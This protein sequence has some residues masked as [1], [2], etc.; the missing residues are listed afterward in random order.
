MNYSVPESLRASIRQQ[1]DR[2]QRAR[3][4][5]DLSNKTVIDQYYNT[6][7]KK[8]DFVFD[9]SAKGFAAIDSVD[10]GQYVLLGV[11]GKLDAVGDIPAIMPYDTY[12]SAVKEALDVSAGDIILFDADKNS[13]NFLDNLVKVPLF[14]AVAPYFDQFGV[15]D[16]EYIVDTINLHFLGSF[17]K[18]PDDI[19][20][21]TN[22][23]KVADFVKSEKYD[24]TLSR[25]DFFQRAMV[26]LQIFSR[27]DKNTDDPLCRNMLSNLEHNAKA[28]LQA[29]FCLDALDK[30]L[31]DYDKY[32][33]EF[34]AYSILDFEIDCFK[35]NFEASKKSIPLCDFVE[36]CEGNIE[37]FKMQRDW[38]IKKQNKKIE[39]EKI[40]NKNF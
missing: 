32:G 25:E 36:E 7:F 21:A 9:Y 39:K 27:F 14:S 13:P 10:R 6:E 12:Y 2:I 40:N 30:M 23:Q 26:V 24:L 20:I 5:V 35:K 19:T 4:L 29:G 3:R 11:C 22:G 28:V 17:F 37:F 33:A 31:S 38:E 34:V 16:T 1:L 18:F 15:A 8:A